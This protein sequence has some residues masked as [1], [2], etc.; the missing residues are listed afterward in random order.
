MQEFRNQRP[1]RP[2][3]YEDT[4]AFRHGQG[5]ESYK[6]AIH[7]YWA[8]L[9]LLMRAGGDVFERTPAGNDI[10]GKNLF[11]VAQRPF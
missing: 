4:W 11:V 6:C 9:L 2:Q 1:N 5:F 8:A 7:S 3:V 10:I